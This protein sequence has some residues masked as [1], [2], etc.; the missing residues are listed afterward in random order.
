MASFTKFAILK[1][2]GDLAASR[3]VDKITVKDITDQ[4]GISRNTFYYHY[5]D[6]YQVLKAYVQYSAE[7][8]IELMVE[9]EGEDGK[10]G[11][12]EIRYLE[13]NRELLCNLYRSAANEEVRNCLQSAS[14]IIF[15]RLIESVSQGMEV[16]AEDKKILSAVCQYTVRGIMTSWMEED[17]ML[18]GE[19]L[20][21][22]L[23]RLDYLFKGAIREAL[24]RSASR[25]Q[26]LLPESKML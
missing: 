24:M 21:Q 25:E 13:A 26:G 17:G 18:N 15:D 4:C 3:P 20:E 11:L 6:I 10:A 16:Q 8:V 23:V 19:T 5:Q 7:H 14:Q 2:F 12:K 1:V 22:V 9:D